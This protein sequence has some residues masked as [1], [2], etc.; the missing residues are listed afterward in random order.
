MSVNA[1]PFRANKKLHKITLY[2]VFLMLNSSRLSDD[3]SVSYK[4]LY[5]IIYIRILTGRQLFFSA[6]LYRTTTKFFLMYKKI[7]YN[8][9]T[10]VASQILSPF[11]V[12]AINQQGSGNVC[13]CAIIALKNISYKYI[14]LRIINNQDRLLELYTSHEITKITKV[15]QHDQWIKSMLT[16]ILHDL[17]TE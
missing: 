5:T 13:A 14:V 16:S 11:F 3:K 7:T 12:S 2:T 10:G 15:M 8:T 9:W 6:G 4:N 17:V 1:A